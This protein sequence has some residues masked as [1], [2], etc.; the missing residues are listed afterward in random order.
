M[1]A[2]THATD[3][4]RQSPSDTK[5]LPGPEGILLRSLACPGWG[6]WAAGERQRAAVILVLLHVLGIWALVAVLGLGE[7]VRAQLVTMTDLHRGAAPA[8]APPSTVSILLFM[9]P[10]LLLELL[11]FASFAD[12][13]ALVRRTPA[14]RGHD[15]EAPRP[16]LVFATTFL[17]PGA[18]HLLGEL[19]RRGWIFVG[20]YAMAK[21]LQVPVVAET[22]ASIGG[23]IASG[24]LT[25]PAQAQALVEQTRVLDRSPASFFVT[26]V[27]TLACVDA[28]S[29]NREAWEDDWARRRPSLVLGAVASWFCPGAAQFYGGR[30]REGWI[31]TGSFLALEVLRGQL[32]T[33][34]LA[35]VLGGL[36]LLLTLVALGH[37][38]W[39]LN[40][41]RP[42]DEARESTTGPPEGTRADVK[43][44]S[45]GGV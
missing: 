27:W 9:L 38:L 15:D 37:G 43:S 10:F 42:S 12:T 31:F 8:A 39:L 22:L 34:L 11:W 36:V 18:G 41:I 14:L 33:G 29:G 4:A 20:A 17:S 30:E 28:L 5:P 7:T 40:G 35:S 16:W 23:R 1:S 25:S 3:D 19:T 21:C 32:G 44:R 13:A 2:V 6:H 26:L 24:G 45:D